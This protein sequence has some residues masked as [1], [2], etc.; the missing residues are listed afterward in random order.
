MS[1]S[2]GLALYFMIWW[3]ALFAVLPFGVKTQDEG[4]EVVPGTPGS[5]PLR[6]PM[7]RVFMINTVV[8]TVVFGIVWASLE[9]N[10]FGTSMPLED[11]PAV[12]TK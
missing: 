11:A 2:L 10:W 5:A 12:E 3:L 6:F 9:Y 8:A 7:R 4:K 1:L